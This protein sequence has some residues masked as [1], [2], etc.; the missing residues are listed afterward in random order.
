MKGA[1][2]SVGVDAN[3]QN[4]LQRGALLIMRLSGTAFR[5]TNKLHL[6]RMGQRKTE[7]KSNKHT[8]QAQS[9]EDVHRRSM[10]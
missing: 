10:P 4:P 3:D 6:D 8:E 1:L 2:L 5:V 9:K 7:K